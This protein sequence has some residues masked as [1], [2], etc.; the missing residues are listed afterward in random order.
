MRR[1]TVGSFTDKQRRE[2]RDLQREAGSEW[3][4]VRARAIVLVQAGWRVADVAE[5]FDVTAS[6]VYEWIK[7]FKKRGIRGLRDPKRGGRPRKYD[8][9]FRREV[10]R[11]VQKGP[12]KLG[13]HLTVWSVLTLAAFLF[14][15]TRQDVSKS[16]LRRIL[17]EEGYR[18]KRPKL[19]LRHRQNR[20]LYER[21]RKRLRKLEKRALK[22]RGRFVLIYADEAEF[23][24]NPG[25][26]AMWSKKGR[27]P[28]VPSAGQNRK[29]AVFGGINYATGR[30]VWHL[31]ERKNQHQF[32]FFLGK[33]LSSYRGWKVVLVLDNVAYHKTQAV[34]DF[35]ERNRDRLEVIWQPP[36][37]PQLNRIE[38]VWKH[39]KSKYVYNEFFGDK[40]G[41]L[42]AVE[43]GLDLLNADLAL[44]RGLL[45]EKR[46][47]G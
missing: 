20:V 46:R 44:A 41:L 23:H 25:L 16:Q 38:R 27:Q 32:L 29:V 8:R 1:V 15:R 11:S 34:M 24:L 33:L 42:R 40:D 9:G 21:T 10:C 22:K 4:F 7:R 12:R 37:S 39:L 6:A 17:H 45:T 28:T 3:E 14:R 43:K 2:L 26:V 13:L 47:A 31:A 35:F 5:A 19:S 36:Y 18:W 30:M